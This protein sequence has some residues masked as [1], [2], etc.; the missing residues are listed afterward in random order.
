MGTSPHNCKQ[1]YFN[2]GLFSGTTH[3]NCLY[4]F[5]SCLFP[6]FHVSSRLSHAAIK[7]TII[8]LIFMIIFYPLGVILDCLQYFFSSKPSRLYSLIDTITCLIT[9]IGQF[10]NGNYGPVDKELTAFDLLVEGHIPSDLAGE[11]VRNGPNPKYDIEE[12]TK[13]YLKFAFSGLYQKEDITGSMVM[14]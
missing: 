6:S 10:L 3:N 7:A 8:Q 4:H 9:S 13:K 12:I 5:G 11:F 14:S 1:Y 2:G